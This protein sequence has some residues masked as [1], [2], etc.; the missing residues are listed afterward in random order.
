VVLNQVSAH[1]RWKC[2]LPRDEKDDAGKHIAFDNT[3]NKEGPCGPQS[4]KWGFGKVTNLTPGWTTFTWE[5]S[6]SHKG[7]FGCI[8]S[9]NVMVK[10]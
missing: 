1:S 3:G 4:G 7:H 8:Y 6:I 5:E 2:P 10:Y 9:R